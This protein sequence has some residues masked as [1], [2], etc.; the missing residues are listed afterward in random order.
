M[1]IVA[2]VFMKKTR[3][4][5]TAFTSVSIPTQLFKKVEKHVEN[6]GFPSVS[7]YVAF[8][9]R[10]ILSEKGNKKADY[11]ADMVKSRLRELGYL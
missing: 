3:A 5:K 7:S 4:K 10:T 9:L 6:T 2:P 1:Q 8:V 11:E